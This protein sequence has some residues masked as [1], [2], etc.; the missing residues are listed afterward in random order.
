MQ[1]LALQLENFRNYDS[2]ELSFEN[3]QT[4]ALIGS[5]AQGKTNILES[6]A[7]LALGKSFRAHRAIE[8]LGWDRPH[9]RIRGTIQTPKTANGKSKKPTELEV[10]LQRAP[11]TKRVK[12]KNKLTTP[13]EFIG[14]LRVVLFTPEHMQLVSG[15]PRLRRQY[16]DRLLVQLSPQYTEA[17]TNYQRI[18]R[19]RNTLLKNIQMFLIV[20]LLLI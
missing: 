8:T 13:K 6:I 4:V 18:L 14:N 17:L 12:L 1:L 7:F 19:Q 16:L 2:L 9:G 10:F 5:N 20:Y 11:E 15:S 3:T